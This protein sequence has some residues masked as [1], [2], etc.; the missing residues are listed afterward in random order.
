MLKRLTRSVFLAG[1]QGK[2]LVT[3]IFRRQPEYNTL[4][5]PLHGTLP[6]GAQLS[7]ASLWHGG[8]FDFLTCTTLLRWACDDNHIQAVVLTIAD[9]DIGWA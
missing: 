1:L 6:E 8:G 7:L 9:L 3:R 2:D 4:G 5:L